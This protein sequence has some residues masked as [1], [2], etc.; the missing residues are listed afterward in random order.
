MST[1]ITAL[2]ILGAWLAVALVVGLIVGRTIRQRDRQI[3]EG[4]EPVS[5]P[6][7]DRR[8]ADQGRVDPELGQF[9]TE[10]NRAEPVPEQKSGPRQVEKG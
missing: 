2:L 9:L 6:A 8:T 3:P 5:E 7:A 10:L 4:S 1:L